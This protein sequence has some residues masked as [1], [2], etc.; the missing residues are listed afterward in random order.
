MGQALEFWEGRVLPS[1]SPLLRPFLPPSFPSSLPSLSPSL[2]SPPSIALWWVGSFAR[3][4]E[5]KVTEKTERDEN[6]NQ[7]CRPRRVPWQR[8][9]TRHM[10]GTE[11]EIEASSRGRYVSPVL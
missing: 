3:M 6:V 4:R 11:E 10:L 8:A 5:E 2:P 9:P 7:P 1:L